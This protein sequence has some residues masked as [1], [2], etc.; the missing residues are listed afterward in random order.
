MSL[1]NPPQNQLLDIL[2][3][4]G[5]LSTSLSRVIV[6]FMERWNVD[7]YRAV[8]ETHSIEETKLA[9]ILAE[10]FHLVRI[11]RLRSRPVD[12]AA[13]EFVAYN[14]AMTSDILPYAFDGDGNLQVA[15][16]DPTRRAC[17]ERLQQRFSKLLVLHVAERSE[18]ESSVQR[19]YPLS[20]QLPITMAAYRSDGENPK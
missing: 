9:D 14:D 12:K 8:L 2:K 6:G 19:H 10:E 1:N 5:I 15:I 4:R 7:A 16:A 17:I 20:L 13:L 11:T 3:R 18:I